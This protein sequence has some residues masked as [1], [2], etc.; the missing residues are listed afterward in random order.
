MFVLLHSKIYFWNILFSV[1]KIQDA[2]TIV[3]LNLVQLMMKQSVDDAELRFL[4]MFFFI[5][6]SHAIRRNFYWFLFV[7][8]NILLTVES[9]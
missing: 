1:M 9:A 7:D 5:F 8:N 4:D 3:S 2:V 6:Q